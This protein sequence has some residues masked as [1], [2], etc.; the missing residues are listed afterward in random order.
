M[1]YGLPAEF[2]NKLREYAGEE[3]INA[4]K[5]EIKEQKVLE[6]MVEKMVF[7]EKEPEKA[8]DKKAE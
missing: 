8:D 4:K 2:A 5:Y 6:K 1:Q 7:T 3:R